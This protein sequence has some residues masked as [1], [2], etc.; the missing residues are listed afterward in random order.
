MPTGS[1]TLNYQAEPR[2]TRDIDI[3]MVLK[4][5]DI[6]RLVDVSFKD[7]YIEAE[8]VQESFKCST[9]FNILHL[10]SGCCTKTSNN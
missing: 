2:M 5:E 3:I 7:Y 10:E 1:S 4:D 6:Q 8:A 9:I